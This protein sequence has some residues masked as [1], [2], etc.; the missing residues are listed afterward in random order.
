[1]SALITRASISS[2]TPGSVAIRA[3]ASLARLRA[4][5]CESDCTVGASTTSAAA[6]ASATGP[7]GSAAC[8]AR[9]AITASTASAPGVRG[10]GSHALAEALGRRVAD[11]QHLL[12]LA[13]AEA[14][15]D[16]R[17]HRLIEIAHPRETLGDPS[18]R[19]TAPP[20]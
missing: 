19:F 17:A 7:G 20:E 14:V 4:A 16:D 3:P 11:D 9:S 8:D 10:L 6:I 1:M 15:A 18:L 12:A 2:V 13:D 5:V